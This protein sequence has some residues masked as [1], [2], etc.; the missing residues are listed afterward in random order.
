MISMPKVLVHGNPET[1]AIWRTLTAELAD[2]G[3]DDVITLSPPG[4]GAAVPDAW[5]ATQTTYRDWLIAEVAALG[6]PV[7]I[8]GH[9]WGAGHVFGVLATRPDLVRTW[10]ADCVGLTHPDYVWHD[11]ATAWQTPEVGEEVIAM[12]F[13]RPI[14]ERLEMLGSLG[15]PG[16]VASDVANALTP[17][18]GDCVLKLYRSAA[19]PAMADLGAK[20]ADTKLPPGLV[21]VATED[22]YAGDRQMMDDRASTYGAATFVLEDLGHWWMFEGASAAADALVAHWG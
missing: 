16:D 20:L 14:E 1:A 11:A 6:E 2:R 21:I 10:A 18:M 4:F 17:A 15:M 9:D 3:V 22:H 7:D 8:V 19:Q 12:M 5:D 13:A